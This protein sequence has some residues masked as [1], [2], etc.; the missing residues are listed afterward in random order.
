MTRSKV[1]RAKFV[2]GMTQQP[3][4]F[5][6]FVTQKV[7]IGCLSAD[8]KHI[9]RSPVIIMVTVFYFEKAVKQGSKT[10]FQYSFTKFF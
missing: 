5:N 4:E 6:L 2:E 8:Q 10:L 3:R 1:I 9:V 7:R